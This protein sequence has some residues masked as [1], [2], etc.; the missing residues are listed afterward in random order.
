MEV[1]M[2]MA[3]LSAALSVL[4][5]VLLGA[6]YDVI[7]FTRVLFSVDVRSPFVGKGQK[8]RRGAWFSY[9]FVTLGDLLF[10][11]VATACMCVFFFLTGDGRMRAYALFGALGGFLLYY[12]TVGRLFIG[13]CS[14]LAALCKK[15][16]RWLFR[17]SL[18]PF[19]FLFAVSKKIIVRISGLPIVSRT[20]ARYNEYK[21]KKKEEALR[22]RRQKRMQKNGYCKNG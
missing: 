2:S 1:S 3:A 22:R 21:S 20:F 13:I 15:A 14:Y 5:G 7:R 17:K 9:V 11:A 12:H 19:R 18:L 4:V 8:R 10:F 6:V 16:I